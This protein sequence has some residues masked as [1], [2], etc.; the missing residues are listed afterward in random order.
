MTTPKEFRNQI[1]G[2]NVDGMHLSANSVQEAKSTLA[3]IRRMIKELR[4][5]KRSINI[6]LLARICGWVGGVLGNC[7]QG[8]HRM[9]ACF[10]R[11]EFGAE[12]SQY[13]F[14]L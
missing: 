3:D 10:S 4:S 7:R 12:S 11:A 6:G 1:D 2:L 8:C 14:L 9:G 5:I 13:L